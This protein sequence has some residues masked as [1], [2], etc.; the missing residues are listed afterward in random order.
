MSCGFPHYPYYKF[1]GL[2][3]QAPK[4]RNPLSF[5][6]RIVIYYARKQTH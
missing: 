6:G 2:I 4:L 5:A 1:I 3:W